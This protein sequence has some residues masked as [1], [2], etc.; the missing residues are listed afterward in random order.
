MPYSVRVKLCDP[1]PYTLAPRFSASRFGH[2]LDDSVLD[3]GMETE[4]IDR[5]GKHHRNAL[6]RYTLSLVLQRM[7]ITLSH[8]EFRFPL[9]QKRSR[10]RQGAEFNRMWRAAIRKALVHLL[11][12]SRTKG[13]IWMPWEKF[14]KNAGFCWMAFGRQRFYLRI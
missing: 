7:L 12:K 11:R 8:Q 1:R 10:F 6:V 4:S 14:L 2:R 3:I 13:M 9:R 5:S